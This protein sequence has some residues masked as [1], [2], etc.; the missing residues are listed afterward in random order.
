MTVIFRYKVLLLGSGA[1]GKTSLLH[2]FVDDTFKMD[3]SATIG[4]QFLSK[5]VKF[6]PMADNNKVAELSI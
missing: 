6:D 2:K 4:A 1:V 5:K 3:Y